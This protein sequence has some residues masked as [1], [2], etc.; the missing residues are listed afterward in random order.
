LLGLNVHDAGGTALLAKRPGNPSIIVSGRPLVAILAD[1]RIDR[2]DALKI[3]IEGAEDEALMPFLAE[4][5]AA[6]LPRLIIIEDSR[7]EWKADLFSMFDRLGYGEHNRILEKGK[8]GAP[9]SHPSVRSADRAYPEQHK[10]RGRRGAKLSAAAR[11]PTLTRPKAAA[12]LPLAP[13]TLPAQSGVAPQSHPAVSARLPR[14][15][16]GGRLPSVH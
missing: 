14:H 4:A 16:A 12:G 8:R 1:A 3:D 7:H 5:P 9:P 15:L 11:Q 13:C 6:L 10:T 2:I